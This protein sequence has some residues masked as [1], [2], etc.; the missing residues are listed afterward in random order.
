MEA[1]SRTP[2]PESRAVSYR[3]NNS[4]LIYKNMTRS[5]E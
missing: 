3:A 2:E 5:N 1:K 4:D